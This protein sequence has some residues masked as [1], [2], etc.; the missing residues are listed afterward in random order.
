MYL[1]PVIILYV[2]VYKLFVTFSRFSD[3]FS[4]WLQAAHNRQVLFVSIELGVDN[5]VRQTDPDK[6]VGIR[7]MLCRLRPFPDLHRNVSVSNT[8]I[9]L[10]RFKKKCEAVTAVVRG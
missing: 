6:Y 2:G 3:K 9:I 5:G 4:P 7:L 10:K 1:I 8:C